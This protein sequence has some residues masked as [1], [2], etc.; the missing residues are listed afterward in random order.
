M[1]DWLEQDC[2]NK[3]FLRVFNSRIEITRNGNMITTT[4]LVN[5]LS[6]INSIIPT[7]CNT[8]ANGDLQ[9]DDKELKLIST[10]LTSM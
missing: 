3:D 9:R 6:Y 10:D 4:C 2:K 1:Q 5:N 8:K 7:I